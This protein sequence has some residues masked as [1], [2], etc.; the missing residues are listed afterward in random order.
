[1]G[2]MKNS[3]VG[4]LHGKVG[5]LVFA[6]HKP[7]IKVVRKAPTRTE[8]PTSGELANQDKFRGAVEYAKK[9]WATQPELKAKYN[10][11]ARPRFQRGFALAKSDFLRPP[12][13]ED[14]D[15]S[16]YA[17]NPGE[18]IQMRAVDNFE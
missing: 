7:G 11:I 8:P 6:K 14:I 12:T 15:L 10:A 3:F 1:M 5:N 18:L 13:V 9:V 4:D 17:G 16:S 2:L